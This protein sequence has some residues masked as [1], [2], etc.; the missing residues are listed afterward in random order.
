M[1]KHFD[2]TLLLYVLL[3]LL[4]YAVCN[5]IMLLCNIAFSLPE[6]PSLILEFALQ[7]INSFFLNRL[8][9]FRGCKLSRLWPLYSLLVIAVCYLIAKVLL[10]DAFSLFMQ[11]SV[12]SA[13]AD[14]LR[15]LLHVGMDLPVFREK[16]VMLLCTFTY[17][18][19]NYFG[20]RYLVFRPQP[21]AAQK[22]EKTE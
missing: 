19:I 18:A 3:G 5:A 15:N 7:T 4:N 6:T 12:M 20:Q 9:T 11:T 1:K 13:A 17:S 8:I 14:W 10:R 21:A 22:G 16:L 2:R